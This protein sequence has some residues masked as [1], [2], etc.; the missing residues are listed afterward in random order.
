MRMNL[1]PIFIVMGALLIV[2]SILMIPP[3]ILA[4]FFEEQFIS[5]MLASIVTCFFGFLFYIAANHQSAIG[6]LSAKQAFAMIVFS[7]SIASIFASLPFLLAMPE[8]SFTDAVFETF[9]G[10]TTTGATVFTGLDEMDK[11]ILL[12]RSILQWVGGIGFVVMAVIILPALQVGGM[13]LFQIELFEGIEKDRPHTSEIGVQI[14]VFYLAITLLCTLAYYHAGMNSFDALNHAMTTVATG[15]YSTHDLSFVYFDSYAIEIIAVCFMLMGSLPFLVLIRACRGRLLS[16]WKDE[17]IRL[18]FLLLVIFLV[19]M[20]GYLIWGEPAFSP[21]QSLRNS[22]FNITSIFTGTGFASAAFDTWGAP[23]LALFFFIMFLG[24]CAGSTSCGIK[25]FRFQVLG[26]ILKNHF[27]SASQ[28][29]GVFIT[30]YNGRR[31]TAPILNSVIAFMTCFGGVYCLCTLLIV[32]HGHDFLTSLSTAAAALANVGPALGE[33]TGP[34]AT[35]ATLSDSLKWILTF[36]MLL[37]RLDLI[38]ILVLF[39]PH[40]W[41]D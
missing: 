12:W 17:Q 15:G 37:G 41:K 7:W 11:S 38:A 36:S 14:I 32:F 18:F 33:V 35:Y 4:I 28:P 10:I 24:G 30:R 19:I 8:L 23:A 21:E 3:I 6:R 29:Y 16:L 22:L 27:R 5:F 20:N 34:S 2:L 13:Q 1:Q 25:I 26:K 9:S 40:F 31:I 39:S